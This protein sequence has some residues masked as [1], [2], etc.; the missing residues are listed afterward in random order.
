MSLPAGTCLGP[1]E[2]KAL[3]G[4]GGIGEV[5]RASDDRVLPAL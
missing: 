4:A 2:I 3:L 5:Y 1:Y